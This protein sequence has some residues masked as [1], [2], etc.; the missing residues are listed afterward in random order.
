MAQEG[1]LLWSP[2]DQ[3]RA[4]AR[5]T[6][7]MQWLDVHRAHRFDS[8]D[9]LRRW[10]VD[11]LEGFWSAVAEW[12]GVRWMEEPQRAVADTRMPGAEW[13][14]GARLNYAE[15]LLFPPTRSFD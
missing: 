8:Y 7:F 12:Y 15:H 11:D 14:R 4:R 10:S 9:E 13:F 1:E 5:M 3:V 6:H 2:T